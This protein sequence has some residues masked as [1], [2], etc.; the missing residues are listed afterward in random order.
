M[1]KDDQISLEAVQKAEN[2]KK[3]THRRR[4]RSS[5]AY[6]DFPKMCPPDAPK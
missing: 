4:R 5:P 1:E 2:L 6:F 3:L